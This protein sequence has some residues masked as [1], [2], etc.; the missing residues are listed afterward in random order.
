MKRKKFLPI[1]LSMLIINT[2]TISTYAQNVNAKDIINFDNKKYSTEDINKI[3]QNEINQFIINNNLNVKVDNFKVTFKSPENIEET[4]KELN[5]ILENIKLNLLK[6]D[7]NT[8]LNEN[9]LRLTDN[10]TYYTSSIWAGVPSVGWSYIKQDFSANISNGKIN[11]ITMLGDSYQSGLEWGNWTPNRSWSEIGKYKSNV[12]IYIKGTFTY[13]IAYV[14]F[15]Y[16][17]TFLDELVVDSNNKL[18]EW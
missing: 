3:I 15:E 2:N 18:K 1:L 10:G 11:S 6:M 8:S 7:I 12:D 17:A 9:S 14:D 5:T 16:D 4:E 13:E